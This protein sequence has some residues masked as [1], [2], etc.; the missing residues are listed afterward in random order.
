MED[1]GCRFHEGKRHFN[2]H[3]DN[4]TGSR[5]EGSG[6]EIGRHL[7]S[8]IPTF[9]RGKTDKVCSPSLTEFYDMIF[10]LLTLNGD[11]FVRFHRLIL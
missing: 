3:H 2:T 10:K 6:T 8:V 7:A 5:P 9:R 11:F 4:C 1:G